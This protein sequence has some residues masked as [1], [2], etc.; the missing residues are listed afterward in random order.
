M[1]VQEFGNYCMDGF[2]YG[3]GGHH[4]YD[5]MGMFGHGYGFMTW[6]I[7]GAV[8][9]IALLFAVFVHNKNKKQSNLSQAEEILKTRFANGEITSEEYQNMKKVLRQ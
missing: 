6:I 8:V 9:I 5:R 3:Y 1:R 7:L 4:L 2:G